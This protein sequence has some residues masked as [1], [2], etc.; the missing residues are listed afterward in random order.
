M[1]PTTRVPLS[2]TYCISL[3]WVWLELPEPEPL[4]L[5]EPELLPEVLPPLE[6]AARLVHRVRAR[7]RDKNFFIVCILPNIEV[8]KRG[9][10]PLLLSHFSTLM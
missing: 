4:V 5:S 6:Q 8:R 7:A 2:F 10:A 1:I 3:V 9:G